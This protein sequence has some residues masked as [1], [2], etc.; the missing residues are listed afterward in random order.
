MS[1]YNFLM[2]VRLSPSYFQALNYI[3]RV[4]AGAGLNIYLTGGAVR[5]LTSG[6]SKIRNLD[7]TVEGS[8]QKILKGLRSEPPHKSPADPLAAPVEPAIKVEHFSFDGQRQSASVYFANGVEAEISAAHRESYAKLGRPPEIIP[9]GIFEDL[10]RRDFSVD[11]MAVS[12]HP[13]SRGLLLDPTNGALDIENRELRALHSR[14][15]FEDPSRI[16]R[17]LRFSLRMGFKVEERTER[18]F[19]TALESKVWENLTPDQQGRELRAVLQDENPAKVLRVF[20]EHGLLA[21]LDRSLTR[22]KIPLDPLEK[23]KTALRLTPG[24]DPFLLHFD[25]LA[26]KLPAADQKR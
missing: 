17:L 21:G 6:Q 1:D 2:E 3:S 26:Q 23:V 12:L 11:A 16:Y 19:E 4:A 14:S 7:F 9:A 22:A 25:A 18:W 5:D 15:F 8:V 13:N 20:A 24:A 10:R